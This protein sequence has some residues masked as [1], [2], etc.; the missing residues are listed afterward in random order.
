MRA[1]L[2]DPLYSLCMPPVSPLYAPCMLQAGG[3]GVIRSHGLAGVFW[4][5][6]VSV[7]VGNRLNFIIGP[8]GDD[9]YNDS[10]CMFIQVAPEP[11]SFTLLVLGR[12]MVICRRR[13]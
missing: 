3:M 9:A 11:A 4:I 12:A 8:K 7:S 13:R 6:E 5:S 2:A 1:R 10:T